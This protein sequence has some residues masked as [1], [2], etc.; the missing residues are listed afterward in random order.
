MYKSQ[1]SKTPYF[2]ISL[3]PKKVILLHNVHIVIH[4]VHIANLAKF[5]PRPDEAPREVGL[6]FFKSVF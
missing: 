3:H 5:I 2:P 1:V 6:S 4:M